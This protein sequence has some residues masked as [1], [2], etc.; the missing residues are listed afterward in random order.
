[1]LEAASFFSS[2]SHSQLLVYAQKSTNI[3]KKDK[4]G[5][6]PNSPA[7]HYCVSRTSHGSDAAPHSGTCVVS[8]RDTDARDVSKPFRF[9]TIFLTTSIPRYTRSHF[10]RFRYNA[11]YGKKAVIKLYSNFAVTVY[12]GGVTVWRAHQLVTSYHY[13]CEREC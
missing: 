10:T 12:G 5:H 9:S 2:N 4:P 8:L 13:Q 7:H 6:L 3:K 1:M 11:I